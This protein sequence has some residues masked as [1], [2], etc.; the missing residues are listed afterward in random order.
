MS[1][2]LVLLAGCAPW[3]LGQDP[4][5]E[6][7]AGYSAIETNNHTFHFSEIGRVSGLDL[8]EK[9]RGFKTAVIRNL[10]RYFSLVGEFSA[11]LS[12]P[13]WTIC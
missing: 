13:R 4:K 10:S 3:M 5:V 8:D 9:G 2:T 6:Y 12:F 11:Q 7:F 1:R